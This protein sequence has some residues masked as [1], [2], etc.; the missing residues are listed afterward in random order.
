MKNT[1]CHRWRILAIITTI[2]GCTLFWHLWREGTFLQMSGHLTISASPFTL[3]PQ[4]KYVDSRKVV[5]IPLGGEYAAEIL[6]ADSRYEELRLSYRTGTEDVYSAKNLEADYYT[7]LSVQNNQ[8]TELMRS[9]RPIFFPFIAPTRDRVIFISPTNMTNDEYHLYQYRQADQTISRVSALPALC[10]SKPI[11]STDGRIIFAS[12]NQYNKDRH[13][14]N[15]LWAVA[16][17][18]EIGA[19]GEETKLASGIFPTWLEE[20]RSFFFFDNIRQQ[21]KLYDAEKQEKII[22]IKDK[23]R[24]IT[25]PA[26]S[27]DKKALAFYEII[28][29]GPDGNFGGGLQVMSVD[30]WVKRWIQLPETP[31][32]NK[33]G[34]GNIR[35]SK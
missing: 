28:A 12:V 3:R 32:F 6:F 9:D 18:V 34:V 13:G 30:G 8:T 7:V 16:T 19:N 10:L 23:V 20:G 15:I 11:F 26:L 24:M 17:I 21:L 33:Y 25:H 5:S 2:L 31:V 35:L 4:E 22:V 27:P 29:F 14:R 1:D